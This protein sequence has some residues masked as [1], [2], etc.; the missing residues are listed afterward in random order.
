MARHT[1][2]WGIDCQECRRQEARI[3]RTKQVMF[4]PGMTSDGDAAILKKTCSEMRRPIE[5]TR[6]AT[7]KDAIV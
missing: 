2:G 7:R 3:L 4:G 5:T 6:G 1:P